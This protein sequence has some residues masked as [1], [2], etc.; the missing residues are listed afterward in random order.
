MISCGLCC[1]ELGPDETARFACRDC[2]ARLSAHLRE[3]PDLYRQLGAAMVPGTAPAGEFVSG[4]RDR[5]LP[6]NEDAL[7]LRAWGGMVTALEARE[8][9]W[10]RVLGL[11]AMARFRG[12]A[13]QALT[14][15]VEFLGSHLWWA[16]EKYPDIDGLA[17]DVR[18]LRG[19]ALSVVSPL[20]PAERPRRLGF[21]LAAV[22]E[23]A[24]GAV[25]RLMP[26]ETVARCSWC[27]TDWRPER[28]LELKAA[29]GQFEGAS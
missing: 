22:D 8:E 1:E 17:E 26:K 6:V 23:G 27:G 18:V 5:H 16:C 28:W 14:A 3:L 11:G 29:Q 7:S 9:E 4:S 19:A 2:Q 15:T 20:D 25:V 12:T 10:R 13:E 24:C 21:C